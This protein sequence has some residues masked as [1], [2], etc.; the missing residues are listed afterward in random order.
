MFGSGPAE[1]A[2]TVQVP[3][4]HFLNISSF[5]VHQCLTDCG[6]QLKQQLAA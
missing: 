1:E 5:V 6:S 3:E 2:L 4:F